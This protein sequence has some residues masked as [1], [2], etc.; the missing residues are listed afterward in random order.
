M[1]MSRPMKPYFVES[2]MDVPYL[3]SMPSKIMDQI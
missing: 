2:S 1:S 3:M